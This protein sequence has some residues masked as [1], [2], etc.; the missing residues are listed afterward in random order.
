MQ[1][2]SRVARLARGASAAAIATFAALFGHVL[3]GGAMPGLLGI[4]VPLVLSVT[5]ATMLAG[6]RLSLFRLSVSVVAS[7]WLFHM[8]FVIGAPGSAGSSA[9]H[10]G[11]HHHHGAISP[12]PLAAEQAVGPAAGE[13]LMWV[14]HLVAAAVTVVFLYR[15]ERALMRLWALAERLAAWVRTRLS[16]PIRVPVRVAASVPVAQHIDVLPVPSRTYASALSR[17]GPPLLLRI[18]CS[19]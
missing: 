8:L 19:L 1:A 18:A 10:A 16:T 12:P 11:H 9:G 7:Q 13:L 6:K 4:A 15:G 17:R 5:V 2:S 3:A 14:S